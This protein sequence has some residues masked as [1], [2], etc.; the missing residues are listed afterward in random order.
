MKITKSLLRTIIKEEIEE[1]F[2]LESDFSVGDVVKWSTLE[3]VMKTTASGR[4]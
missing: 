1:A 3:K 4:Q 2:R